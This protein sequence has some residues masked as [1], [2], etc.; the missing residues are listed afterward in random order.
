VDALAPIRAF[1]RFQRRHAVLAIPIAVLRKFSDDQAGNAAALIAFYAFFSLFPLLLLFVTILGFVLQSDPG[2]EHAVLQSALKQFPIVGSQLSHGQTLEGSGLGLAVGA[3]GSVLAGLG[4]TM[5]AQNAFNLVYAVPIKE[6]PNFL[7][8]RLRGLQT[9]IV[10]G[11]LQVLSTA[12]SGA[13]TGGLAGLAGGSTAVL[14]TVAGVL[15][16]LALNLLLFSAVF[17]MLTDTTIPTRELVPGILLASVLWE[18]LQA[19]GGIYIA[20]IKGDHQTYGTFATVIGLIVWLY[21][22]ARVVVYSAEINTVLTRALWPRSLQAPP[23]PADRRARAALAKTQ[24]HDHRQTVD[25]TFHPDDH[26]TARDLGNPPYTVD[27]HPEPG[28]RARAASREGDDGEDGEDEPQ[29]QPD[30][31][32]SS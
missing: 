1:D 6:R 10:F 23:T 8:S 11:L 19:F 25:V 24:E 9:L 12:A 16:S 18:I 22:G 27:P 30:L 32:G 26:T 7:F 20:H 2:A 28:E 31:T 13:V 14:I 17:R 21:L 29:E 4:V 5:A 3:I 15:L